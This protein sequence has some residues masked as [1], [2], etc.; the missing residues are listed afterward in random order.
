MADLEA[1]FAAVLSRC[2]PSDD[3]SPEQAQANRIEACRDNPILFALIYLRKHVVDPMAG[4]VPSFADPHL[5]WANMARGWAADEPPARDAFVA[6]RETGKS[7]WFFLILP[8]WAAAYGHKRFIAAFAD[9]ATQAETH[10]QSFKQE[11]AD[12]RLLRADFPE[13][14][15]PAQRGRSVTVADRQN[16]YV[17]SSGFTFAARG[18]DSG[19]L[20]LK[21]SEARPDLLILDDIEPGESNYSEYQIGKRLATVLD[22]VFPLNRYADVVIV[23]TVTMTGSIIHQIRK[24]A[25]GQ[26]HAEWLDTEHINCH[27]YDAIVMNDDGT[28]RSLWPEKWSLVFLESIEHTRSYRKNYANDPLGADGGYWTI[29]DIRHEPLAGFT[30]T[31]LQIDPAVTT[32]KRSDFTALAVISWRPAVLERGTGVTLDPARCV[33]RECV[34]VRLTGGALRLKVAE[35]LSAY[36]EIKVVRIETNQGGDLW[37]DV[38]S[39]FP[40]KVRQVKETEKKEERAA[41]ALDFYQRGLVTHERTLTDAEEQMVGFPLAPHDDM[42]DAISAGVLYFLNPEPVKRAGVKTASYV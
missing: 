42:V 23:G 27:H 32:S 13:L 21:V 36:P 10:L 4:P 20:G 12:N 26:S 18:I 34:A 22:V 3:V 33:V 24:K 35:L 11:L 8:M 6:P 17:S 40:V 16:M 30:R 38:L 7:T 28:R 15:T 39:G 2:V 14:C 9:S 1:A 29:D 25:K 41:R 37:L 19:N 31:L 5:D